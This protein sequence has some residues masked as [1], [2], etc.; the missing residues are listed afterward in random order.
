MNMKEIN[1]KL[2]LIERNLFN[3][4][5]EGLADKV[6]SR[7]RKRQKKS[8]DKMKDRLRRSRKSRISD[9]KI[10]NNA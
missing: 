9:R 6:N 8:G 1:E 3:D 4:D 5:E 10:S 2:K 7:L